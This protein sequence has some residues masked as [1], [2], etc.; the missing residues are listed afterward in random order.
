VSPD[1]LDEVLSILE[2]ESVDAAEDALLPLFWARYDGP[3]TGNASFTITRFADPPTNGPAVR[4]CSTCDSRL[5]RYPVYVWP[6]DC[7][8]PQ[9]WQAALE[10]YTGPV[11]SPKGPTEGNPVGT[12]EQSESSDD[13]NRIDEDYAFQT[14]LDAY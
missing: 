13:R 14:G 1:I 3:Y 4:V 8:V 12:V 2:P 9:W 7:T 5:N 11:L 6:D 10:K